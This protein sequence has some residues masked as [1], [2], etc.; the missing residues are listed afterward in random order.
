MEAED[1]NRFDKY[2]RRVRALHVVE[3]DNANLLSKELFDEIARTR[4][5]LNVLPNLRNL[6]W[7]TMQ[8]ERM[9]FSLMFMHHNITHF[10][11]CLLPTTDYPIATYL[12]EVESRMP[13]LTH[14]DFRF[15]FS[16]REVE[17]DLIHLF[18]GLPRLKKIIFPAYTFTSR[19]VEELSKLRD[20]DTVQFEFMSPS[21]QGQGDPEDVMNFSP[22]LQKA[23]F[24]ALVD[25]SVSGHLADATKL[26]TGSWSPGRLTALYVHVCWG[27]L[28]ETVTQFV[29]AV[30][31]TCHSLTRLY[32]DFFGEP[33]AYTAEAADDSPP[34]QA[35]LSWQALRPILTCEKLVIFELR[36]NKPIAVSQDDLEEVALNWPSLETFL[37]NCE[38]MDVSIAPSLTLQALL[39]FAEHCPN[40]VEL[41][42]YMAPLAD[43][44]GPSFGLAVKPFQSLKRLCVGLSPIYEP[45]PVTLFLS[46]ICPLGCEVDA[47]M[48]WPDGFAVLDSEELQHR[49]TEWHEMWQEVNRMLPLLT[50]LRFDERSNRKALGEEV[51][52][53]RIRNKI[54]SETARSG[55][56]PD[57]Q[58]TIF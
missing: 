54:L 19:I 3:H 1:W 8:V 45:G 30:S 12:K 44:D 52:D 10:S 40:L 50:Q 42:L 47:G 20:L 56:H 31:E 57:G 15:R 35:R 26:L 11:V 2:A 32:I 22:Q 34:S 51:E 14:L 24:P 7:L 43:L 16:V 4:V 23:A 53:L 55:L 9:R 21:G 58:C 38:P 33:T 49:S 46:Q 27:H 28:P 29:S 6:I 25:L 5:S 48:T 18:K 13:Y 37:L 39:P 41:G 17:D 36:W